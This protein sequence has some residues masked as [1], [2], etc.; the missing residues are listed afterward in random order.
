MHLALIEYLKENGKGNL[1]W[2]DLAVKF[3]IKSGEVAR[4]QWARYRRSN[5]LNKKAETANY[6]AAL[7]DK[8]VEFEE[9]F[10]AQTGTLNYKGPKEI[11]TKEDLFRECN[12]DE[13]KWD[14]DKMVVNAWG[15]EGNQNYQV[16]AWL[17]AKKGAGLFQEKFTEFLTDYAPKTYKYLP[18]DKKVNH[19]YLPNGC[20]VINKQDEH[21]NKYDVY[22]DNNILDRFANVYNKIQ[23]VLDQAALSNNVEKIIYVIGSDE[24]NSEWTSMTTKGTPQ[25]NILSYED[26][27]QAICDYEIAVIEKLRMHC[28][29]LEVLYIQGNHDEYVGWHLAQFLQSHFKGVLDL[30]FDIRNVPTKYI[31]YNNTAMMFN[32][33]DAIKPQKLAT[34]F[35]VQFKS[36]WSL[37]DN[38]YIFTGDK[39]HEKSEDFN[40]IMFYQ[41]PALST[42]I[43]KW[44]NKEG[45]LG[46]ANKLTAF[47][48]EEG[49]G[50]TNI[51]KR[52]M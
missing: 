20:L 40:G 16:K 14:L 34:L 43:G 36:E 6:I 9:N 35:P 13:S 10:K 26:A 31:R 22:G 2:S 4:V 52:P 30:T 47:M 44:E 11:K 32:H 46:S 41:L 19:P 18:K 37:C 5:K 48:I 49:H 33:G 1:S 51:F 29:N 28:D 3:N 12:V 25:K 23:I 42:A 27:F 7:E 24:F 15:K 17:S 50:I 21:L 8:I 39:H 45:H 38:F